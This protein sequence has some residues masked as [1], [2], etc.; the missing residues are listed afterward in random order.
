MRGKVEFLCLVVTTEPIENYV[1]ADAHPELA[2]IT[3][4]LDKGDVLAYLGETDFPAGIA[5]DKLKAASTF[6]EIVEG[7]KE[8]GAFDVVLDDPKILIRLPK[9]DY[10]AYTK[11]AIGQ[12]A[13]L[14]SVFQCSVAL[15]ALVYALQQLADERT[16]DYSEKAWAMAIDWRLKTSF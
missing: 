11:P 6:M 2:G 4:D 9:K 5:F 10:A 8:S 16:D 14:A 1:N 3:T 15:P 13:E 7:E 12:N